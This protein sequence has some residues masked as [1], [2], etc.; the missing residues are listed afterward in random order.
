MRH[1]RMPSIGVVLAML[2]WT[3]LNSALASAIAANGQDNQTCTSEC[4]RDQ[5]VCL[6][7]ASTFGN[8][9]QVSGSCFEAYLACL[10]KCNAAK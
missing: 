9:N 3:G 1:F 10:K 6:G 5:Q 8:P 4:A 2:G 7:K